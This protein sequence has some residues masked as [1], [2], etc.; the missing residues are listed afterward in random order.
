MNNLEFRAY[1]KSRNFL[2]E[3]L[4]IHFD[5]NQI[6]LATSKNGAIQYLWDIN[7]VEIMQYTGLKDIN[8]TKIFAGDIIKCFTKGRQFIYTKEVKFPEFCCLIWDETNCEIIGNKHQ[9]KELLNI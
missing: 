6:T 1:H 5:T 3:V 2:S 9:N 7:D 8:G 4:A